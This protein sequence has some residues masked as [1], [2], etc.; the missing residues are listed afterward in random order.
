MTTAGKTYIERMVR[1]MSQAKRGVSIPE[2]PGAQQK[3]IAAC[4]HKLHKA[5]ALHRVL[6]GVRNVRW[7]DTQARADEFRRVHV[8]PLAL[9][10]TRKAPVKCPEGPAVNSVRVQVCVGIE[11][12]YEPARVVQPV[13]S[14][15]RPGEYLQ[16]D[17][18]G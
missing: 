14:A 3:A 6:V 7:F 13:F 4:V 15:M 16:A 12:M 8:K 10:P 11:R 2:V 1:A 17:A 5:G 9:R 18:G